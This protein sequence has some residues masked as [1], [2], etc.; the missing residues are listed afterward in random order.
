MFSTPPEGPGESSCIEKIM[1][2]LYYCISDDS[3]VNLR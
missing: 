3:H 1:F 2:D